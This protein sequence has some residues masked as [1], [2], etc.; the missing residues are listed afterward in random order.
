MHRLLR[1]I[2]SASS[3]AVE[4]ETGVRATD[5]SG[6]FVFDPVEYIINSAVPTTGVPFPRV[7]SPRIGDRRYTQDDAEGE[8]ER[9]LMSRANIAFIG[10]FADGPWDRGDAGTLRRHEIYQDLLARNPALVIMDYQAVMEGSINGTKGLKG[11]SET[12]ASGGASWQPNDW[13]G[14]DVNGN[15]LSSFGSSV[16]LNLTNFV[17]PDS[18]GR[19]YPHFIF[20][21]NDDKHMIAALPVVPG[22]SG[23][24]LFFDVYD[25]SPLLNGLDFNRDGQNDNARSNYDQSNPAHN[26]LGASIAAAWRQGYRDVL[27]FFQAKYPDVIETANLTTWSREYSGTNMA[28]S[29]MPSLAPEHVDSVHGGWQ[30]GQSRKRTGFCLSGVADDGLNMGNGFGFWQMAQNAYVYCMYKSTKLD[31]LGNTPKY[32]MNQWE[33]LI[34]PP[35]SSNPQSGTAFNLARWAMVSTLLDDGYIGISD[36][37]P[38]Q[39]GSAIQFDEFGTENTG[40]T[41]L[42]KGYL[43]DPIDPPQRVPWTGTLWK[44]RFQGGIVIINTNNDHT[45]PPQTVPV[46]S[47]V[48]PIGAGNYVRITGS[49][50]PAFNDG[51]AVNANFQLNPI[52]A[53]ILVNA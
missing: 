34:S 9:D 13:I 21:F 41:S 30:E 19:R 27:D 35:N 28:E 24:N 39:Y 6:L 2:I 45:D 22:R 47:G 52:D 31:N 40:V 18:N 48:S 49:Q 20:E 26:P 53:I 46:T 44:R 23:C 37:S 50:D 16:N 43:G 17:T 42:F 1:G 7:G 38:N 4:T 25:K 8:T 32:V 10:L 11:Q 15:T 3:V 5:P 29:A 51:S 33:V 14:R 12:G 36:V